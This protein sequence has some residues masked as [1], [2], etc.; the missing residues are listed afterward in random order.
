MLRVQLL[1]L[2]GAVL[3]GA[4]DEWQAGERRYLSEGSMTLLS[5]RSA[6]PKEVATRQLLTA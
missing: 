5:K 6:E 4:H 1:R 2:A 3:V